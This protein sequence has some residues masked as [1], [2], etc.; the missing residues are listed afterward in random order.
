MKVTSK[1]I[2][3]GIIQDRFGKRGLL[4][5][6]GIPMWSIP[7]KIKDAP[8][9]TKSYAIFLE[10]KDAIP[11]SEGFSWIHWVAANITEKEIPENA[12][13]TLDNIVQ[14]LNSWIS[15]QGGQK[16]KEACRYYGGMT[17][18]DKAHI[19]EIHVYALDCLVDLKNGFYANELFRKMD[20]HILDEYTLKGIYEA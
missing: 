18:P 8:K 11:V 15:I 5:E 2:I 6:Y 20:G 1:G 4:D 13:R 7:L 14:G 12:S 19:Y 9:K 16:P 3:N 10:D 17:P